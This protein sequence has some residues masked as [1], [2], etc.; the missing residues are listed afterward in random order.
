VRNLRTASKNEL[1]EGPLSAES[2]CPKRL[3]SRYGAVTHLNR[4]TKREGERK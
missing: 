4:K 3:S 1:A 2:L